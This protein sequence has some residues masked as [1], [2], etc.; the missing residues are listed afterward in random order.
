[1]HHNQSAIALEPCKCSW[2]H[3]QDTKGLATLLSPPASQPEWEIDLCICWNCFPI[4]CHFQ[5]CISVV[6]IF[7]A[8]INISAMLGVKWVF[9][10]SSVALIFKLPFQFLA[11]DFKMN[12]LNKQGYNSKPILIKPSW[13]HLSCYLRCWE[14]LWTVDLI[15]KTVML[16]TRWQNDG[17]DMMAVTGGCCCWKPWWWWW[18][19]WRLGVMM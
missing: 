7:T 11:I 19:W 18:Q 9:S 14:E 6:F 16:V 4:V 13:E 2:V 8:N 10:P 12:P 15:M 17:D 1:M 5:S 3:I